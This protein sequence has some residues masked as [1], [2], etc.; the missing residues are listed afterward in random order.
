[1]IADAQRDDDLDLLVDAA[2]AAR[3]V[4]LLAGSAGLARALAARL[5]LLPGPVTLPRGRWLLVAGSRH[6]ATRAQCRV[7]AGAGI[8]VLA[9]P[10]ESR[11]NHREVAV[12]LAA[13]AVEMLEAEPWDL[14]AVTGG[15]TAIAL[16]RAL[17]AE[18][19]DVLGAPC[20][21]LALGWLRIPGRPS[22]PVVTKAGGFGDPQLW[23]SLAAGAL[24]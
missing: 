1:V 24:V 13:A 10:E 2:L 9:S 17:G 23:I 21:G 22:V 4:P 20:P 19:I 16:H 5:E 15:E 11:D 7:A 12:H 8:T 18:R 3:P 6:P 14:V